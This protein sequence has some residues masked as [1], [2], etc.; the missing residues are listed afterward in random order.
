MTT[1]RPGG[2][3]TIRPV[4]EGVGAVAA[5]AKHVLKVAPLKSRS[6]R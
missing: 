1:H 6:Q 2:G 5:A 3:L 4:H